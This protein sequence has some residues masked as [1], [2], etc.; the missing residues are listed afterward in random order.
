MGPQ[1]YNPSPNMMG[2]PNNGYAATNSQEDREMM[3]R[4][5]DKHVYNSI[6]TV[7]EIYKAADPEMKK[8]IKAD[9]TK[10]VGEMP[11]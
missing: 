9:L 3:E 1:I 4:N 7:R 2:Q 8:R 11:T 5:A 6:T 10:L